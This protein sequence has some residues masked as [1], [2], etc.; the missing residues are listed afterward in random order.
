MK[1]FRVL[2]KYREDRVYRVIITL[3]NGNHTVGSGF[4]I[5]KN[6]FLTCFHVAFT[7]ELKNLRTD[8]NFT[9]ITGSDEHLR[10]KAFY[11]N[12]VATV[13]VELFDGTK[14][15]ANL[16]NFNEK[17]DVALFTVELGNKKIKICKLAWRPKLDRGDYIFFNGFPVHH[18]Y[19][20]DK[21]PLAAQDGMI[22]S[23]VETIIGG[24]KYNHLQINSINLGGNSG[25]P[26][27]K[28]WG[29]KVIGIVNGNMNYG[30]DH[31]MTKNPANNQIIVQSLRTPLNIAYA[32]SIETLK[33]NTDLFN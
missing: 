3:R 30:N 11:D 5:K 21:A 29:I 15:L 2:A 20:I 17:Y 26:L 31:V 22:S 10:L 19:A 32:T 4:F 18:S 23:F 33:Q 6:K 24:E 12:Q 25:A 1:L 7:K 27:F 13:E 14:L 16:A 8:L 9:G 28:K